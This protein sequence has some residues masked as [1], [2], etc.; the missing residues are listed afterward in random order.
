MHVSL[1]YIGDTFIY[2]LRMI[3]FFQNLSNSIFS[4]RGGGKKIGRHA[5]E[6]MQKKGPTDICADVCKELCGRKDG[7]TITKT[8]GRKDGKT[9]DGR[10]QRRALYTDIMT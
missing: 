6:L 5:D 1:S 4:F 7:R 3:Q 9:E 8:E 10:R 2:I